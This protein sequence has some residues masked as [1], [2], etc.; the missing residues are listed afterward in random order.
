MRGKHGNLVVEP[1]EPLGSEEDHLMT[2]RRGHEGRPEEREQRPHEQREQARSGDKTVLN[3]DRA[4]K[5]R[6][7]DRR[8]EEEGPERADA[9]PP[10]SD[11][12]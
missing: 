2:R 5:E 4:R 6:D 8:L 1:N 9:P 3:R 11:P 10:Q 12:R 7:A